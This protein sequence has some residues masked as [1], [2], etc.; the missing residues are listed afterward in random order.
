MEP[1]TILCNTKASRTKSARNVFLP[2][3]ITK[4][5]KVLVAIHGTQNKAQTNGR[6][7]SSIEMCV[8]GVVCDVCIKTAHTRK[9]YN[10]TQLRCTFVELC[11]SARHESDV[12]SLDIDIEWKMMTFRL[13]LVFR[14]ANI[15]M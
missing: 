6:I 9:I 15:S 13:P 2:K 1:R 7:E 12:N 3:Y 10:S 14:I 5:K 11:H 4:I 8:I